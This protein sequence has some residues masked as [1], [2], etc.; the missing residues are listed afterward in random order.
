[1]TDKPKSNP[2]VR[3]L[4]AVWRGLDGVR[5]LTHLFLMLFVLGAFLGGA[6]SG[7]VPSIPGSAMLSIAPEGA[8]VEELVG[9]AFDRAVAELVESAAPQTLIRDVVDALEYAAT[10]QRIKGVH[11]DLSAFRG[12][13]IAKLAIVADAI[14]DFRESGKPVIASADYYSQAGYYLAAHAD[15]VYMHPDGIVFMQGYGL[16]RQYFS[17]AIEK[18]KLDW[19]VFRV[20]TYKSFVEPYTRMDMSQDSREATGS[21]VR[22]LWDLYTLDVEA[23]RGLDEGALRALVDNLATLA[24][25]FEGDLAAAAVAHDLIDELKNRQAIRD[26][27]IEVAGFDDEVEDS[28]SSV[29]Q[30]EYL[31]E[32]RLLDTASEEQN[33]AI[34][35]AAGEILDGVQSPGQIG[36][37]STANL[38]RQALHDDAVKAVVLRVDSPGGSAFASQVIS[39]AVVAL[40]E[41]GKP[42]MVSMS[43]VAASGGYWI[44][45]KADRIFAAA[46]TITGSIGIFGMFPTYQRTAAYL[47]VNADGVGATPWADAR[48]SDRKMSEHA[49]QVFQQVINHGYD[50][51]LQHV[52]LGRDMSVEA[53]DA[54]GQGRIWTGTDALHHGLVDQL[55][56]L[57]DAVAAAAEA[58]GLEADSYGSRYVTTPLSPTEQ[59]VIDLLGSVKSLGLNPGVFVSE[60]RLIE[61]LALRFE[62]MLDPLLRF[63]DP[64][65]V[66]AH[67]F[68]VIE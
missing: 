43:G 13:S 68:C 32:R 53:A 39:N 62:A 52:A 20:G 10:D 42:V 24:T 67:C 40:Q 21:V 17:D 7:S 65:G 29:S 48:R 2:F 31:R 12:G 27:L 36:G 45:A 34:V 41:A 47:G 61:R 60:P 6:L 44:A 5:K 4:R 38:L 16:Y 37:D 3:L 49:K 35:V 57:D 28:F 33:V 58:A 19:N 55:G 59:M 1:M 30:A 23:A 54:I 9:S 15:E 18:L 50:D 26:R 11:L 51:F 63:N 66:Y 25:D 64:R 8:L 14:R 22:Q 46:S 56:D